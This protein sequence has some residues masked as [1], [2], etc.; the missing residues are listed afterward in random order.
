MK[1]YYYFEREGAVHCDLF[2]GILTE[3]VIEAV[4]AAY[5]EWN[6]LTAREQRGIKIRVF[7]ADVPEVE[8][9]DEEELL[10]AVFDNGGYSVVDFSEEVDIKVR[11]WS[12]D[13]AAK[14][15]CIIPAVELEDGTVWCVYEED[16]D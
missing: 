10:E 16:E 9:E 13:I 12:A 11:V 14:L 8:Y 15:N 4:N 1:R 7:Y 3:D 2:G 6:H 5:N